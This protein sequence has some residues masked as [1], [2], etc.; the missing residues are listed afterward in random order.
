MEI[1]LFVAILGG[2]ICALCA[3][4]KKR[5]GLGWFVIG[6]LLPLIGFILIIV[7]P[8][9]EDGLQEPIHEGFATP[10]T[11]PAATSL[12]ELQKL[13]DLRDRGVLTAQEFETKKRQIL[14]RV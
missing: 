7:L 13:A 9:G 6:F 14:D 5:S 2:T 1:Y 10:V 8:P 3:S 12:D 11:K 4:S